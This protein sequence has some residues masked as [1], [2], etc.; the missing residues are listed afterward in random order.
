[1]L[2]SAS[3]RTRTRRY[4]SSDSNQYTYWKTILILMS[5]LLGWSDSKR[6]SRRSWWRIY[7]RNKC[8]FN[9]IVND[10]FRQC[11]QYRRLQK[12][13]R[14]RKRARK[15]MTTSYSMCRFFTSFKEAENLIIVIKARWRYTDDRVTTRGQ[16]EC[17]GTMIT[18]IWKAKGSVFSERYFST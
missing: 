2:T 10:S 11:H 12:I 4:W 15:T 16:N 1:M 3:W 13:G 18:C 6:W 7:V 8:V 17:T 14:R 9:L 5:R